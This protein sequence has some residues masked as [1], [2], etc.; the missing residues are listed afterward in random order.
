MREG[1][2]REREGQWKVRGEEGKWE[3]KEEE[4]WGEEREISYKGVHVRNCLLVHVQRAG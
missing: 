1:E 3:R 2:R 4:G